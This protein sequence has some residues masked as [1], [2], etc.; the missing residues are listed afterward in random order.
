VIS[1][2]LI[3]LEEL[4]GD[5]KLDLADKEGKTALYRAVDKGY[6]D[7]AF[8]LLKRGA[9]AFSRDCHGK[10]VLDLAVEKNIVKIVQTITDNMV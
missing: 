1:E 2:F 9:N 5:M 6:T 7:I 8:S 3:K 10:T 4:S